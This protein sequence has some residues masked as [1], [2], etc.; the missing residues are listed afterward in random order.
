[1]AI[2]NSTQLRHLITVKSNPCVSIYLPTHRKGPQIDQD[3]I[4]FKNLIR[5]AE[6]LLNEGGM[7]SLEVGSLLSPARKLLEDSIFWRHQSDGL[8]VFI[9]PDEF[10]IYPLPYHFDEL[11]VV[12]DRYHVKPLIPVLTDEAQ[13]YVLAFSQKQVRLLQGSTYAVSEI[14][15]VGVSTS[16]AETLDPDRNKN[17]LQFHTGAPS[18]GSGKR[19]AVYHGSGFGDEDRKKAI[20]KFFAQV[21]KGVT[22]ILKDNPGPLVLAGVDYLIPLYRDISKYPNL[23]DTGITGNFDEVAAEELHRLAWDVVEPQL[24]EARKKS[25]QRFMELKGTDSALAGDE[26]RE[27]VKSAVSGRI[28]SLFVANGVQHWGTVDFKNHEV[29]I[30]DGEQSGDCDLLDL[31]AVYTL[32]KGGAVYIMANGDANSDIAAIYRY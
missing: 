30:H 14:D 31:A 10:Q 17:H 16:L 20:Q 7:R 26:V 11:V 32:T 3:R 8:A 2:L 18:H 24:S 19:D 1:M 29:E 9:T 4:R 27:V 22:E 15:L 6:K 21:D 25:W 28:D 13:F 12:T 5:K 23:I